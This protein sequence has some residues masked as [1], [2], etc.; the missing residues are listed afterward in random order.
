MH[1]LCFVMIHA[2]GIRRG[3]IGKDAIGVKKK[4]VMGKVKYNSH[5]IQ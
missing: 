2:K 5:Y 3:L 4:K 1:V